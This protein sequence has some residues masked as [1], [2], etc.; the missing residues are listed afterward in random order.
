[1]SDLAFKPI[2]ST[3]V[4]DVSACHCLGELHAVLKEGFGLPDYYGENWDA[5]WD[6]LDDRFCEEREF[7]V[8]IHGFAQL[9]RDLA[10]GC[11]GLWDVFDEIAATHQNV[12]FKRVS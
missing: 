3:V 12:T 4:L 8:E 10:E 5:L 2:E 7:L 11:A 1:M 9:P 6:C